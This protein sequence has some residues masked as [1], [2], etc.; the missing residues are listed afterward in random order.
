MMKQPTFT[1]TIV[2]PLDGQPDVKP[3]TVYTLISDTT[4]VQVL[5]EYGDKFF[6]EG[7]L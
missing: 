4:P 2:D 3:V 1:E 5:L 7:M 6:K